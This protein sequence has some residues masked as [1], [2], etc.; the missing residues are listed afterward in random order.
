M[1]NLP[2]KDIKQQVINVSNFLKSQEKQIM[3]ALPKH[4]TSSRMLR[5]ALTEIRRNPKLAECT[6]ISL[7]GS[8]IQ[9]A[10]LGL[11]PDSLTGEA[12]L[13]PYKNKGILECI[14][15][16]GYKGIMELAYRSTKVIDIT[17]KEVCEN[18]SFSFEY[19]TNKFL[20][21]KPALNERGK[22]I[23]Y[24][25]IA[26]LKN[27]EKHFEVLSFN[28][29]EKH[30]KFSKAKDFGPWKEH[31]DEMAKK[32]A[33][34]V[35]CKYLPKSSEYLQQAITLDDQA[36][37][38]IQNNTAILELDTIEEEKIYKSQEKENEKII[39]Q[40]QT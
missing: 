29:I 3:S 30:R 31:Y 11:M 4:L 7:I 35:V 26:D 40:N 22:T 25:A 2:D 38:G 20:R 24:Y 10:Q 33:I 18:D 5:I 36:D 32:T 12:Y 6:P 23:A 15:I 21:H 8:I 37:C 9:S 13:I 28:D 1:T 39:N 16:P 34:K 17:A 27:G 14:L 19:G